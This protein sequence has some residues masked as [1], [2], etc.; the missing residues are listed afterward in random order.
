MA[1]AAAGGDAFRCALL[2]RVGAHA[3][4]RFDGE[5]LDYVLVDYPGRQVRALCEACVWCALLTR[6]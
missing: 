1:L 4:Q 5:L 2:G 6:A 3:P